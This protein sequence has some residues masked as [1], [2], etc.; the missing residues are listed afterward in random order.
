MEVKLKEDSGKGINGAISLTV[1]RFMAVFPALRSRNYQLFFTGQFISLVGTWLQVVAQGWLVLQLTNSAFLVG[2][3]AAAST[4]PTL[5][6]SLFGG[7]IV[8]RFSKRRIL[9]FTQSASMALAFVLGVLTVLKAITVAE[10]TFLAF[11]LG[12]VNAM[13]APARQAF[14][15]EMVEREALGSAIALNSG[16]FNAARVIGPSAAGILIA[17]VS[18]GGAFIINSVS[19]TAV[20]TALLFIRTK[21]SAA[22]ELRMRPLKAIGEG[23]LYSFTHPVIRALLLFTAITSVFGWSYTTILPVVAQNIFHTDASGLGHLYAAGGLGAIVAALIVSALSGKI[24]SFWFIIGGNALFS[25]SL[26]L[27]TFTSNMYAALPLLFFTGVGILSQ[28]SMMNTTI[29]RLVDDKVRGRVMSIYILMFIGLSP[30]GNLEAGFL[31]EYFGT[32][33][34][35]RLGALVVFISGVILLLSR[36]RIIKAQKAYAG[37]GPP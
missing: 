29:Q 18:T 3:V 22:P 31:A 24:R 7:V 30:I 34:A 14:L 17:I 5:F 13:D 28:F 8:D 26:M 1:E 19:Y 37:K 9:L 2:V 4:A 10:I 20:I 11:L 21:T 32:D 33:F 27:F 6:L 23:V 12:V 15:I 16:I 36:G 25:I 35:I